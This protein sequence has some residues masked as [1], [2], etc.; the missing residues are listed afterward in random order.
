[1]IMPKQHTAKQHYVP[2]FL[3]KCFS[4]DDEHVFVLNRMSNNKIY[5]TSVD[6]ICYEN[7][8]YDEKWTDAL[9]KL[10]K[11]VLDNKIE[12]YLADLETCSA[13]RIKHIISL[14]QSGERCVILTEED[15]CLISEFITTLYLRNPYTLKAIIDYYEGVENERDF[16]STMFVVD[17]L[18]ST[19]KWGSP[20]SLL[21]Y[22]KKAGIFSKEIEG[23][24]YNVEYKK[25]RNMKY[26]FWHAKGGGIVTSSFPLHIMSADG[27][28]A[29]RIICPLSSEVALVFFGKIPYPLKTG[30]VIDIDSDNLRWNM[31]SFYKSYSRNM[32]RLYISKD[33]ESLKRIL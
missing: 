32:A 17:Y 15:H 30:M 21:A 14:I 5:R 27:E 22:S 7:D 1:M 12:D 8:I 28:H 3:L 20:K 18:F 24:P 11:Y 6:S 23:S 4:C 16:E 26:V 19:M 31:N 33:E 10:G 13:P 25:I 29:E 9:D 2:R